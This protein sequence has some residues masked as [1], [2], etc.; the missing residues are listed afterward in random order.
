MN[1]TVLKNI[2]ILGV[3]IWYLVTHWFFLSMLGLKSIFPVGILFCAFHEMLCFALAL[4]MITAVGKL[5]PEKSFKIQAFRL[6]LF[7]F[8]LIAFAVTWDWL[9]VPH[10]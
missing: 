9:L 2:L 10:R 6:I 1:R 8:Y 3:T 4:P 7:L 5:N